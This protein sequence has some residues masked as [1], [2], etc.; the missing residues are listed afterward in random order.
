MLVD[1]R[2][3]RGNNT[4]EADFAGRGRLSRARLHLE[5]RERAANCDEQEERAGEDTDTEQLEHVGPD[6]IFGKS[7]KTGFANSGR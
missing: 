5:C 2:L 4:F 7:A 3:P 1:D 6:L